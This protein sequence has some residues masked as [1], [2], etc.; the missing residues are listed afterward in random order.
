MSPIGQLA[1][2]RR[3]QDQA[4]TVPSSP[5]SPESTD[6]V[7]PSS[8]E[9]SLAPTSSDN[10]GLYHIRPLSSCRFQ[11]S[12]RLSDNKFGAYFWQCRQKRRH[13]LFIE[14][15][16]LLACS[17]PQIPVHAMPST[18]SHRVGSMRFLF[19]PLLE[20]LPRRSQGLAN[21]FSFLFLL[22]VNICFHLQT[23]PPTSNG[24]PPW[25]IIPF[26]GSTYAHWSNPPS[27]LQFA[28]HSLVETCTL[29]HAWSLGSFERN[30]IS[31]PYPEPR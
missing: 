6:V 21:D 13:P 1:S 4:S 16:W 25:P 20:P 9:S 19:S 10:P 3:R 27:T 12:I 8:P 14:C 24:D 17:S 30:L 23:R 29:Q 26:P 7:A 22:L 28:P 15:A 18:L 5:D 2:I 11:L 31:R